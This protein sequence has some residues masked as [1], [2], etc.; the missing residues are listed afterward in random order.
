[1]ANIV[2]F[3]SIAGIRGRSNNI[4]YSA[5][6][7]A[8]ESFFE[9]LR[10]LTSETGLCIQFYKLGYISTQQSFGKTLLFPSISPK[11]VAIEVINNLGS[12][13]GSSFIPKYWQLISIMLI[14][15][16]WKLFK[17]MKF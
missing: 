8:L 13:A 12:D 4:I 11:R 17:K 3:G 14:F 10:H 2:G 6:K 7:R 1:V 15:M 5:S 9:S 16:P